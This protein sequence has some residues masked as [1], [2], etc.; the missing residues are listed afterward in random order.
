MDIQ[1]RNGVS[2]DI[3]AIRRLELL[4]FK[5]P[6]SSESIR[7]EIE[8]NPLADYR[9]V[10]VDGRLVGYCGYWTIGDEGNITN[11]AIDP[12]F[13][14]LG[15]GTR[16]VRN[17]MENGENVNLKGFTLEVRISNKAAIGLYEKLGFKN[18]GIRP[19]YYQDGEDAII[20]WLWR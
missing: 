8:D 4:C 2:G 9:V 17:M 11:V 19:G 10:T 3:E 13:R 12:K 20:M 6:W 1:F 7:Q 5:D 14:G 16:L 15:L 18:E